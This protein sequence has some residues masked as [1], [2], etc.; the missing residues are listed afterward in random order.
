MVERPTGTVTFLFTDIEGSTRLWE[1]HPDEMQA[2]LE[3]HDEILR[4]AI[5]A[6]GGYVF[7]TGGDSFAAA[8][9]RSGDALRAAAAAQEQLKADIWSGPLAV[10]VRMGIHTGEAK[11]R[12]GDYFGP[13][14]NR[15]AR[16]MSAVHGGRVL[17]S[18]VTAGVTD[19][20]AFL[21][22]L[23]SYRLKDL[24]SPEPLF[25][26]GEGGFPPV[27]SLEMAPHNLPVRRGELVGRSGDLQRTV[28]ALD[29]SRLV[30]LTGIGGTG[31]T[32]LALACAAELIG[33][34]PDGVWFVDLVP[35]TTGDRVTVAIAEATG[36]QASSAT[37]D[38]LTS[39]LGSRELLLVL[40]NCEHLI[41]DVADVVEQI[42]E[43][44]DGPRI[45]A[46]SREPLEL[47]DESVVAVP[48]LPQTATQR[49]QLRCCFV[50]ERAVWG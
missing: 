31:K 28:D 10:R 47:F 5:R 7:A 43:M 39:L 21:L 1:E 48:P 46:T 14:V 33:E 24:G 32:S 37:V 18:S 42:L 20:A 9:G 13:V 35:V 38:E 23:G 6:H 30:T 25:Q 36:L 3:R 22:E 29:T 40:D 11:E 2:A 4:E 26:L 41:D 44:A 27:R 19:P 12:A 34:F 50:P 16:I 49:L 15:A 45:L 8:F 17:V